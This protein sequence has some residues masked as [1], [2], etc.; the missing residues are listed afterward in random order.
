MS[1]FF[2]RALEISI[3]MRQ[4]QLPVTRTVQKE[5]LLYIYSVMDDFI[6]NHYYSHFYSR[7][8]GLNVISLERHL[9]RK[10]EP[11]ANG[12]VDGGARG[13]IDGVTSVG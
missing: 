5:S 7:Q 13:V 8:L 4:K 2:L 6:M 9:A 12:S 3:L 1:F 10:V 11:M